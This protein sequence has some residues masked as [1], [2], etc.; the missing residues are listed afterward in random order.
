MEEAFPGISF[1]LP[2][3]LATIPGTRGVLVTE[4]H[5]TVQ[6][7]PDTTAPVKSLFLDIR[8]RVHNNNGEQ[9]LKGIA[10]HPSW[11]GNPYVYVTYNTD[12]ADGID[13]GCRLSRFTTTTAPPLAADP[14]S[15]LILVDQDMDNDEAHNHT[16]NTPAFGPDGYLY[17]G[18]GDEDVGQR[19]GQN[20]SQHIDRNL[21][22]CVI[23]IDVDNR[24]ENLDPNPDPPFLDPDSEAPWNL[25]S[26]QT[27]DGDLHVPRVAGGTGGT[28]HYKVPIDNP[29]V[30]TSLGGPWNGTFNG[31][32]VDDRDGERRPLVLSE[33][34]TELYAVG[35]RNP[36]QLSPE[37]D[38]GDGVV[39]YVALGDVGREWRE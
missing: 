5:G 11:P 10:V 31:R 7:I 28:A 35:L 15:E 14:D 19:D 13:S 9:A 16:I 8:D 25:G 39:D 24:P 30:H 29:F 3:D 22:S 18:F 33:I 2:H 27:N 17:V 21:W 1:D 12:P 36:W 34:R 6:V 26:S 37:D 38:D 4:A 32:S 23:R 20:N